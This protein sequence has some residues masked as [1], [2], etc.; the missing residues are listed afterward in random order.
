[1]EQQQV[2]IAKAG[3]VASLPARCSVI[4]AANPKHGSYN[5]SKTVAE[6]LNM[7]RPILS[8]FDLVF[9]LRDRADKDQDRLV[10]TNI[11][12][13]YRKQGGASSDKYAAS[14]NNLANSLV[15]EENN[16]NE[17]QSNDADSPLDT[18]VPLEKRLA[19]VSS[20]NEPLPAGLVRDY[21]A[22]AREFAKPK[23][24]QEAAM[25]LK[26]YYMNLRYPNDGSRRQDTVPIT[27]RQLEALI[28][29]SQARAKSCLREYVLKEDALDVVELLRRSVEQVHT[30]EY[31]IIDRARGGA[32][33]QSN[34]KRRK[35]FTNEIYRLIGVGADCTM[36]DLRRVA[37]RV[38]C[39]LS[40]FQT[41]IDDMRSNGILMKKAD[42]TYQVLS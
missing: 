36:D 34:R 14:A 15:Q 5:M 2:S 28:R 12:N 35:E 40:E 3:V 18:R 16:N 23:L 1:M 21:I 11:M 24:T 38:E 30:D 17:N 26:E 42:G 41:M 6:N 7:A 39:S 22:Y 13:L 8:R 32:A 29:L 10:S 9:I 19:W 20:F 31:G 37:D 33:G 25:I 4:A 27:T